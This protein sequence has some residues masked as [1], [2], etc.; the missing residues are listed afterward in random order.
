MISADRSLLAVSR[1]TKVDLYKRSG[2]GF[3]LQGELAGHGKTITSVDIAS[4]S[5][6]IDT[7]S[8]GT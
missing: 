7:C 5:S 2:S 6:K 1:D 8:R 3:A 4:K